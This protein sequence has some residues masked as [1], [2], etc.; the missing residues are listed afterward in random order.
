MSE[1]CLSEKSERVKDIDHRPKTNISMFHFR[2]I[3]KVD[4]L[5]MELYA[6][7]NHPTNKSNEGNHC[8]LHEL[9]A[10]ICAVKEAAYYVNVVCK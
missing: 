8:S 7:V 10:Y 6:R 5:Q 3:E 2:A 4:I 1:K 9:T